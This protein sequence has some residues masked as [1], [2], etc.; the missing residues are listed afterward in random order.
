ML[1]IAAHQDL[2]E[3]AFTTDLVDLIPVGQLLTDIDCVRTVALANFRRFGDPMG[4]DRVDCLIL[5]NLLHLKRRK[6]VLVP[7]LGLGGAH[8][9]QLL[10]DQI[11]SMILQP[12]CLAGRQVPISGGVH[13]CTRH[14]QALLV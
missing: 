9:K 6:L 13:G 12:G 2:A 3:S 1:H 7:E 4:T 8:A 10:S 14:D 11:I 5:S